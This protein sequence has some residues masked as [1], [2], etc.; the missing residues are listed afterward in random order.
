MNG[1]I[2]AIRCLSKFQLIVKVGLE[3]MRSYWGHAQLEWHLLL[4]MLL[5]LLQIFIKFMLILLLLLLDSTSVYNLLH[6]EIIIVEAFGLHVLL[7][8]LQNGS[9]RFLFYHWFLGT[10]KS[11]VIIVSNRVFVYE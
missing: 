4:L 9:G 11:L 2:I 8:R 3:E 1:R 5:L 7:L 10:F 6:V